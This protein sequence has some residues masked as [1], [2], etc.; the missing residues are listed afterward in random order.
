MLSFTAITIP[1]WLCPIAENTAPAF[2]EEDHSNL[3]GCATT[4]SLD[5][6]EMSVEQKRINNA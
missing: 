3:S 5:T 6:G 4:N 1:T 2:G